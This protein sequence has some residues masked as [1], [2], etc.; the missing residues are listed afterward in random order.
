MRFKVNSKLLS[1]EFS[2]FENRAQEADDSNAK[3]ATWSNIWLRSLEQGIFS[4]KLNDPYSQYPWMYV[5]VNAIAMP[6]SQV[7]FTIMKG[8]AL[9]E[10]GEVFDLFMRPNPYMSRAELWQSLLTHLE[11]EGNAFLL[12]TWQKRSRIPSEMWVFGTD[13]IE[14]QTNSDGQL[15][16][17]KMSGNKTTYFKPEEV[18]HFRKFNPKNAILGLSPVTVARLTM[19]TDFA[20]LKYNK[21]VIDNDA[22]P[23]GVLLSDKKLNDIQIKQIQ[24]QFETR[25]KGAENARKT[26]VLEGLKYQRVSLSQ[27]DMEFLEQRRYSR[28]EILAIWR[29][30]KGIVGVTDDLNYATLFGQKRIF[31]N[32]TLLPD[33]NI[34]ESGL[35]AQFFRRFAPDHKGKFDRKSVPELQEDYSQKV[36]SAEILARIGYPINMINK[37]LELGFE[38]VDW[39]DIW[40][41]PMGLTPIDS[42]ETALEPPAPQPALPAGDDEDEEPTAVEDETDE[43]EDE[44]PVAEEEMFLKSPTVAHA[45]RFYSEM[46]KNLQ[47][48]NEFVD[49]VTPIETRFASKLRRYF[50]EQ[51]N[52]ILEALLK[53]EKA[54]HK[55]TMDVINFKWDL[56]RKKLEALAE[57]A[58]QQA[59][60]HGIK[61]GASFIGQVS[62]DVSNPYAQEAILRRCNRIKNLVCDTTREQ[63]RKTLAD[64]VVR[65]ETVM[66][67]S[68]RVKGI[69]DPNFMRY[70]AL[71][72]ART[73][74]VASVNEGEM[75]VMQAEGVEKKKW[76]TAG[77][78]HVRP[79]H[80]REGAGEPIPI[81][82][83][84]PVT[85]LYHPGDE[86]GEAGEVINCRC[87]MVPIQNERTAFKPKK[88]LTAMTPLAVGEWQDRN[89][90]PEIEVQAQL[91]FPDKQ[92]DFEGTVIETMNPTMKEFSRLGKKYPEVMKNIKYFGTYKNQAKCLAGGVS[93]DFNY[94][95]DPKTWGHC[96]LNG[97]SIGI[98]PRWYG[99]Y[100]EFEKSVKDAAQQNWHPH[101]CNQIKDVF[102]HEFGHAVNDYLL[103]L[104]VEATFTPVIEGATGFGQIK[105][106]TRTFMDMLQQNTSLEFVQSEYSMFTFR[107][108][109]KN[110]AYAWHDGMEAFAEG[111]SLL[112]ATNGV[113]GDTLTEGWMY[114]RFKL[115]KILREFLKEVFPTGGK[116]SIVSDMTGYIESKNPASDVAKEFQALKARFKK[117]IFDK[118]A[119][120]YKKPF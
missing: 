65:G 29:I 25:H 41:A 37:R 94:A 110:A 4:D 7:P 74:V 93:K 101:E 17:W 72:I 60:N 73:E 11:I 21:A 86:N 52:I 49:I 48:W 6:I 80:Q 63:L 77:D 50:F 104:P 61:F 113:L 70:R 79:T 35:E 67:L 16:A 53:S 33:V 102:A 97:E 100:A 27:K 115:A 88:P 107:D 39:G 15:V 24:K 20:A 90:I 3:G 64:G 46:E 71:R 32:D 83:M 66:Q 8:D 14:P 81:D 40:F 105:T 38:D 120:D 26:A 91:L 51:R 56:E 68:D 2:A 34:I 87:C 54:L 98:N 82:A 59:L 108:Y 31:W 42:A 109:Y 12:L 9:V 78:E 28:E 118:V 22:E 96:S 10:T 76:V 62:F 116:Y 43:E 103:N 45:V 92:F 89:T 23:S 57:E 18:I 85:R 114:D 44:E 47:T 95:W 69:F 58:Y 119:E 13:K 30:P 19:E 1:F 5:A 55:S 106:T 75:L 84:F 111:F 99:N 36:A 117:E 112:E